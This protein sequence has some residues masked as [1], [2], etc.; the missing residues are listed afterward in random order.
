MDI[1]G[2]IIYWLYKWRYG[3]IDWKLLELYIKI[4]SLYFV[5]INKKQIW[6]RSSKRYIDSCEWER[7]RSMLRVSYWKLTKWVAKWFLRWPWNYRR[8]HYR[9]IIISNSKIIRIENSKF[10]W[11]PYNFLKYSCIIIL[12]TSSKI[13][14]RFNSI[15]NRIKC[16][17]PRIYIIRN[18][19]SI[20]AKCPRVSRKVLNIFGY[21]ES[22]FVLTCL[23]SAIA[24]RQ[25]NLTNKQNT[26][27]FKRQK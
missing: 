3:A 19:D 26:Y 11:V 7:T 9:F 25:S 13:Y 4:K 22:I 17:K 21:E 8:I 6:L 20:W 1:N 27:W 24:F 23:F 2:L 10:E 15:G 16:L 5:W 18:I 12:R 14:G